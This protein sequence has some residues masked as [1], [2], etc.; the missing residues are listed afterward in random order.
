MRRSRGASCGLGVRQ[1]LECGLLV[2]LCAGCEVTVAQ[3]GDL[4]AGIEKIEKTHQQVKVLEPNGG[5]AK[6]RLQD[7]CVASDG[8]VIALMAGAAPIGDTGEETEQPVQAS[9]QSQVCILDADGK[10]LRKWDLSFVGQ[11]IA[12]GADGSVFVG[13]NSHLAHFDPQ[14]KLLAEA[15]A[16]QMA[17]LA[18]K[19]E[20]R[21]QAEEQLESDKAQAEQMI[22]TFEDTL[23]DEKQLAELQ[24][25]IETQLTEQ[26]EGNSG[27]KYDL[28]KIYTE[29]IESLRKQQTQSIEDVIASITAKLQQI[30]AITTSGNDVFIACPMPKG[31]GFAVWRMDLAFA[32]P[33]QIIKDLSG[34]CGQMDIQAHGDEV[35]VAENSKHRVG[36]YNREGAAISGFGFGHADREGLGAGFGGCCNPMNLCFTS[37]GGLLAAE[38]NGV[39]KRFTLDGKYEGMV[40]VA[41]VPSGC[42]NSAIGVSSDGDRVYYIDIQKSK[43]LVLARH[44][45]AAK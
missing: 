31:Y 44:E 18:N 5:D 19:E 23:K 39:V 43:I 12:T 21:E 20:L 17:A 27:I 24:K 8:S 36:R 3:H 42:K 2:L 25:Q 37:D 9:N 15:D 28:K 16:P 13:G 34:C 1:L 45:G 33:K 32:N 38:S 11:T 40:G 14:G 22:K 4:P 29:Q 7:F 30:N 6:L 10:V 26:A 35:F 41:K